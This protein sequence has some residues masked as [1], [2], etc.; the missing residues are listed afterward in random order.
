MRY[1]E[2]QYVKKTARISGVA[3]KVPSMSLK[4]FLIVFGEKNTKNL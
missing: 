4:L 2:L 1:V 3:L